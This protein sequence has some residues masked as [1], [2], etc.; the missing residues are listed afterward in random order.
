MFFESVFCCI[1]LRKGAI[2]IAGFH[3]ILGLAIF[4]MNGTDY[5]DCVVIYPAAIASVLCGGFLLYGSIY[6]HKPA[7]ITY[8]VS[9]AISI[10]FFVIAAI[11]LFTFHHQIDSFIGII[12]VC[13]SVIETYFWFCVY[14]FFRIFYV[15]SNNSSGQLI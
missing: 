6:Y 11:V 3:I 8:L 5:R 7:T 14:S 9:S 4:F 13:T 2:G 12:F 10:A 1:D 15:Q